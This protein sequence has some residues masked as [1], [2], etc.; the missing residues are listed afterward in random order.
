MVLGFECDC[1]RESRGHF[2]IFIFYHIGKY[3]R[4]IDMIEKIDAYDL[5]N[6]NQNEVTKQIYNKQLDRSNK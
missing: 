2:K 3:K 6:L 4:Q 5:P 1:A